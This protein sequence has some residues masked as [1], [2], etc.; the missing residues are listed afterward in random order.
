MLSE[1][2]CEKCASPAVRAIRL[3]SGALAFR[4]AEHAWSLI[5]P[6]GKGRKAMTEAKWGEPYGMPMV[7]GEDGAVM[8]MRRRAQKV[9]FFDEA[10]EQVGPEHA[11]VVPAIIWATAQG[12]YDPTL[13]AWLTA[14][15]RAEIAANTHRRPGR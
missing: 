15:A 2:W 7:R 11:N 8:T 4:C 9:R 12:W 6:R 13:P 3:T 14:G 10:G 1:V 5:A